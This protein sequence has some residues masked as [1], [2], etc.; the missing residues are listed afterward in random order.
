M[1]LVKVNHVIT[2]VVLMLNG[3]RTAEVINYEQVNILLPEIVNIALKNETIK[4]EEG[5]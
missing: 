1:E 4:I 2:E 5:V 3:L